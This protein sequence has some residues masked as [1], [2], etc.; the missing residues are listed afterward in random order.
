MLQHLHK[1]FCGLGNW[2]AFIACNNKLAG[3]KIF[4]GLDAEK[5]VFIFRNTVIRDKGNAET[6]TCQIDQQI[7]AGKLDLRYQIQLVALEHAV[8]EF[9]GCAFAVQHEDRKLL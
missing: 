9:T 8:K 1:L 6:D 2:K 3:R 7:V 4:L 5:I